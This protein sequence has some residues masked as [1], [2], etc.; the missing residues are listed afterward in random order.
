[1]RDD[2]DASSVFCLSGSYAYKSGDVL[3]E[4]HDVNLIRNQSVFAW[5]VALKKHL[6]DG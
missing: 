1:M 6:L 2:V 5:P 3:S 4:L